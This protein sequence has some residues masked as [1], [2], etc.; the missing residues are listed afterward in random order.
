[1][2]AVR[3]TE[4]TVVRMI[5]GST[6]IL[7]VGGLR[8]ITDPTF[9]PP[10]TSPDGMPHRLTPPALGVPDVGRLDVALVSHDQHPD[11][12]D[13]SGRALLA[14]LPLVLTTPAGADR[15]GASAR[16]LAPYESVDLDSRVGR[17]TVTAVPAQH[18]PV[19]ADAQSGP[20]TGFLLAGDAL[21]TVYVSGDNASLDV[22][23]DIAAQFGPVDLALLFCGSA[24]VP[25]LLDGQPLTLTSEQTVQAAGILGARAVVPVH[26][27]GWSHY[28]EDG[29]SVRG[30]FSKAG[31]RDLVH[32]LAPGEVAQL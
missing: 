11:N 17:L 20:V 32:V 29:Q 2:T 15:L 31:L 22:V 25:E 21:P 19:G 18:R 4:S 23:R 6:V 8:M 30:A 7:E 9:D 24:Q 1:M 27:D 10:A 3:P 16:G 26:C 12:L 5:G 14:E 28:T 13:I